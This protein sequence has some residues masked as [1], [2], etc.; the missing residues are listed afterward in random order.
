MGNSLIDGMITLGSIDRHYGAIKASEI[1]KMVDNFAIS[2]PILSLSRDLLGRKIAVVNKET[3]EVDFDLTKRFENIVGFNKF[4]KDI[5]LIAFNEFAVH[6]IVYEVNEEG[7]LG[8]GKLVEVPNKYVIYDRV[9]GK[10]KKGKDWF[11]R[12]IQGKE[13][14]LDEDKFIISTYDANVDNPMGFGLFRYGVY[15]AWL[16]LESLES[17]IRALQ[18]KYG[19]TIPIFGY[20]P[21]LA[22]TEQGQQQLQSQVDGLKKIGSSTVLGIPLYGGRGATL[23]EGFQTISLTDLKIDMH[24][25]LIN[26]LEDKLEKFLMGAKFSK[27]DSG[28]QAKDKV[29]QEQKDKMIHHM[30]GIM[31]GEM[32]KLLILD[33]EL[34]GYDANEYRFSLDE[35]LTTEMKVE[36]RKM[37]AEAAGK[38]GRAMGERA[39]GTN[40]MIQ[41]IG[42]MKFNNIA[43]ELIADM[44]E[45]SIEFVKPIV[46]KE[47]DVVEQSSSNEM[48]TKTPGSN[49]EEF[50]KKNML[51]SVIISTLEN[52]EILEE[53]NDTFVN[54]G[55]NSE[56]KEKSEVQLE[57]SLIF[58]REKMKEAFIKGYQ[59]ELDT[60][61]KEFEELDTDSKAE[62]F[63]NENF[64][65]ISELTKSTIKKK[66]GNKK[67]E[68]ALKV[69]REYLKTVFSENIFQAFS[70]GISTA[71]EDN[72]AIK[73]YGYYEAVLDENTTDLCMELNGTIKPIDDP[74]W[75][76]YLPPN[77][78][79]CR[80]IR[81][82]LSEQELLDFGFKVTKKI[83]DPKIEKEWSGRFYQGL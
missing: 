31:L 10:R 70:A 71:Q 56:D 55:A 60:Y 51:D 14:T 29:Q 67:K 45:V 11:V 6:E 40:L 58:L 16:D 62:E 34:H 27:G 52:L 44:L 54:L 7:S 22:E 28:S 19:S 21:S 18:E 49:T 43:D 76:L 82:S 59:N 80:S 46:A 63:L 38:E 53:D 78:F 9:E 81:I 42:N 30:T 17:K 66:V 72:I 83:V 41:S 37:E 26:R 61:I 57:K 32:Q 79:G 48:N 23:K 24:N 5:A 8:I 4:T 47:H 74:F 64:D 1:R 13:W 77:H 2:S 39:I 12:D 50:E 35:F 33:S 25:Y 20:D 65:K 3:E 36:M 15:Q 68:K 73:P 75:D 69:M